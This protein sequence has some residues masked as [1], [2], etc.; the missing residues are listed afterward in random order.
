MDILDVCQ[1]MASKLEMNTDAGMR[2]YVERVIAIEEMELP[3]ILIFAPS[4]LCADGL[5]VLSNIDVV[6]FL[7]AKDTE[8][9]GAK[10]HLFKQAVRSALYRFWQDTLDVT[11]AYYSRDTLYQ[12]E[13]KKPH[14]IL[15]LTYQ[16]ETLNDE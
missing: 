3:T 6:C 10:A 9:I 1:L 4:D 14:A 13:A 5:N 7:S 15:K 2:V 12:V 8:D 16:V 11:G